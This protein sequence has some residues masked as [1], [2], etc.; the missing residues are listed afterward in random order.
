MSADTS[1]DTNKAEVK[2]TSGQAASYLSAVL[3]PLLRVPSSVALYHQAL[4]I[5]QLAFQLLRLAHRGCSTFRWLL[6]EDLQNCQR[7]DG[8]TV[9]NPFV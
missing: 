9:E 4:N 7:I 2:L 6:A 3:D 5:Q 1:I 8:L